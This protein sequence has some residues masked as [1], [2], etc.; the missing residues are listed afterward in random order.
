MR[1]GLEER[2]MCVA[3]VTFMGDEEDESSGGEEDEEKEEEEEE[4]E[5]E[6]PVK[7]GKKKGKGRGRGR[8]RG[9]TKAVVAAKVVRSVKKKAPKLGEIE[10][11]VNGVVIKEKADHE[12]EW[13]VDIPVGSNVLEVGEKGGLIWKVYT[14][15]MAE[16]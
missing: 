11:K 8:P 10:V 3:D 12:G 14:E 15:R 13:A 4:M 2:A 16:F 6:V 9:T 5:V 1:L 7:N